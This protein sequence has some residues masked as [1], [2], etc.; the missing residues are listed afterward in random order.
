MRLSG[1]AENPA[2]PAGLLDQLIAAAGPWLRRDLARR[3]DLSSAQARALLDSGDGPVV[4]ALLESGAI[5]PGDVPTEDDRV[6]VVVAA[7]PGADPDL[8]RRVAAHPDPEVRAWLAERGEGLP[9]DVV[10]A[11]V[12]D[13][14]AEVARDAAACQPLTAELAAELLAHPSVDLRKALSCNRSTPP[15]VL[16]A[17]V[18]HP[19]PWVRWD[20]AEHPNL[21]REAVVA[22]LADPLPAA[23]WAAARHPLVP[24]ELLRALASDPDSEVR[25]AVL[26]NPGVPLDVLVALVGA[27]RTGHDPLPVIVTATHDELRALV[28]SPV[29][30]LRALVAAREDLPD[31][32]LEAFAEDEDV[33]VVKAVIA[34]PAL[35][36]DRLRALADRHGPR[37]HQRLAHNP[38]CPPDLLDR[39]A[40]D[41]ETPRKA[42]RAIAAHPN[43]G[44][45]TLLRCLDD[46]RAAEEAAGHPNLPASAFAVLLADDAPWG[47]LSRAAANPALP[48]ELMTALLNPAQPACV[49]R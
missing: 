1:L 14:V 45:E 38:N 31:D 44:P 20:L 35:P 28:A 12:R 3:D 23:R 30:R 7:R 13:P 37:L 43:A 8:V 16:L 42:Y 32:L 9:A 41:P 48:V 39:M 2:L 25:Q 40:R 17:L 24:Q 15:E 36:E 22:L 5:A 29:R 10:A 6:A 34:N 18:D 19:E 33:V 49:E 47:A 46:E 27:T 4:A 26:R 11:L 21:P